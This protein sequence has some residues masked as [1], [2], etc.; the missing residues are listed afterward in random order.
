MTCAILG[1][2]H[3]LGVRVKLFAEL[4]LKVASGFWITVED[5]LVLSGCF[6]LQMSLN[7]SAVSHVTSTTAVLN[8][9]FISWDACLHF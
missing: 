6:C 3:D 9:D 4:N 5:K 1:M 8:S 2:D 7:L